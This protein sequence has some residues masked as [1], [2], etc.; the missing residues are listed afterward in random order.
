MF[1][2][3]IPYV[4]CYILLSC[5]SL[6][7]FNGLFLMISIFVILSFITLLQ[8]PTFYCNTIQATD[9]KK[10]ISNY[11]DCIMRK[12]TP[13]SL[14]TVRIFQFFID[15]ISIFIIPSYFAFVSQFHRAIRE[16]TVL[17]VIMHPIEIKCHSFIHCLGCLNCNVFSQ[18]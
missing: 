6:V 17:T 16:T 4:L 1:Y 12:F 9:L 2:P 13:D 18:L 10:F 7:Y 11:F 14:K 8:R 5:H 15:V 3:L